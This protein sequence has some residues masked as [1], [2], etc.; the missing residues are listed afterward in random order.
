MLGLCA[1]ALALASCGTVVDFPQSVPASCHL[2]RGSF[3]TLEAHGYTSETTAEA[4]QEK[5]SEDSYFT[6]VSVAAAQAMPEGNRV[7]A[8]VLRDMPNGYDMD[9]KI[10]TKSSGWRQIHRFDLY[11]GTDSAIKLYNK[12]LPHEEQYS[13]YF[14]V[15]KDRNPTLAKAVAAAENGTWGIAKEF[16]AQALRECPD[17]PEGY[18]LMAALQRN[19]S[20]YDEAD[21]LLQT[22]IRLNP[23]K[24]KY[25]EAL[26]GNGAMRRN[27]RKVINQLQG[28]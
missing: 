27:E 16:A 20:N 6:I 22:A 10:L 3:L 23:Q 12:V 11:G 4:F 8:I 14:S 5:V 18:Y 7:Y 1:A 15:D 21:C 13:M 26:R 17:D 28:G 9:C 19:D 25:H 2:Q 24:K